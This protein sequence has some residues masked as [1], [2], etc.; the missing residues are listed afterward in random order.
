[1]NRKL[2]YLLMLVFTLGLSF[3]ACS[4][5]DDKVDYAKDVA[6]TYAGDLKIPGLIGETPLSN[7]IILS[8]A[9]E[10]KVKLI[11]QELV[12]PL[13]ATTQMKVTGIEVKSVRV[14]KSDETYKLEKTTE[15]ITVKLNGE[16]EMPAKV[17]V[18][19]TVVGGK[20][21]LTIDVED[22]DIPNLNITFSGTEK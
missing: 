11:L 14:S 4:D 10:N 5:D 17:T 12:I 18:E 2:I 3:T 1:M 8:R 9:S 13:N 7:E 19:G 22:I 21:N 16:T 6:A 20:I 15:N